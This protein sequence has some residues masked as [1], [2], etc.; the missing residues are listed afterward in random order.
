M[1]ES[2]YYAFLLTPPVDGRVAFELVKGFFDGTRLEIIPQTSIAALEQL[3][4]HKL[5]V[6]CNR[7]HIALFVDDRQIAS[8]QDTTFAYG[9][10]GLGVFGPC[11]GGHE[12]R[13]I[14]HDLL[15]QAIP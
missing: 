15:V 9:M 5:A 4:K 10:V 1:N 6:E 3:G 13:V 11:G 12:C 7:G 8:V 14:A 2:G